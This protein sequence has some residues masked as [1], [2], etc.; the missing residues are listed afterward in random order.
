MRTLPLNTGHTIPLLGFGTWKLNGLEGKEAI[1]TALE[2]G[3]RHIDTAEMYDNHTQVAAAIKQSGIV[4]DELFIT[5]KLGLERRSTA[6]V[7]NAIEQYLTELELEYLD[8]LLI[9]W[10]DSSTDLEETLTAMKIAQEAGLVHN[11]GV[12]NFT[13]KH[14]EQVEQIGIPIQNNQIELHPT[15]QQPELVEYCQKRTISVTAY[16]PLGRTADLTH[17]TI[18][19][20]ASECDTSAAQ[21]IL[22]WLRAKHIIAIPKAGSKK[23]MISNFAS[24]QSELTPEYIDQI[25]QISAQNNRL[26]E[27]E[28]AE[29]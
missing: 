1:K 20:I 10:P 24:L 14:L 8:L 23:H 27:P 18:A 19:T 12:S 3:Y 26:V 29:F 15:L 11:I 7:R 6:E 13:I 5:S 17:P 25:D 16:C 28:F 22:Q 4:R 2:V 21:V 9:H